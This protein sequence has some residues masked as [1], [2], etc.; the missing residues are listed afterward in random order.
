LGY[1][2]GC[3]GLRIDPSKTAALETA[4]PP[5]RKTGIRRFLRMCGVYRRFIFGFSEVAAAL[6]IYLKD[7]LPDKFELDE[8]A[9]QSHDSLQKAITAA[10]ILALTRATGL[11]VLEVDA[12]ASQLGVQLLQEQPEKSFRPIGYWSRHCNSAECNYS[13][14]EREA[15]AI[16]WGIRI[17]LLYLEYCYGSEQQGVVFYVLRIPSEAS[18]LRGVDFGTL[19][20]FIVKATTPHKIHGTD[21]IV[22]P[23][24]TGGIE[25]IPDHSVYAKH[26]ICHISGPCPRSEVL[27]RRCHVSVRPFRVNYSIF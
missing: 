3:A 1:I 14:T 5:I 8:A 26:R 9:L 2:V 19:I 13:T 4:H 6:T 7:D 11:Y 20:T 15:L 21:T 23:Y 24:D 17:C 18:N 10:P 25:I 12:S 16:V 22:T 27:N